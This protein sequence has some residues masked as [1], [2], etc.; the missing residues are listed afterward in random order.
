MP[1]TDTSITVRTSMPADPA[2]LG[3]LAAAVAEAGG[4]VESVRTVAA[5]AEHTR[6]LRVRIRD[7]AHGEAVAAAIAEL[8]GHTL[9]DTRSAGVAAREGGVLAMRTSIPVTTRDDLAMAYTPGVARVCMAIHHDFDQAWT[10]TIKANSVMVVSD[11]SDVPGCGKVSAEAS[12][13]AC[14]SVALSLRDGAGI[15][16]FPLPV[17][18][19]SV[20]EIVNTI[21]K[22]SSVFAGVHLTAMAADRAAAVQQGLQAVIDIPVKVGGEDSATF[23]SDWRT[24]IDAA[25]PAA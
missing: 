15:D 14:E 13:P 1:Q 17:D 24:A 12:L 9:H 8:T 19:E 10:Y 11:G 3:T 20:D 5:G 16:A 4:T 18:A 2:S 21:A 25:R 7:L 23:A 6:E 22:C